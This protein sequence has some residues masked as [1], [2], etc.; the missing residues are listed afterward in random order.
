MQKNWIDVI[1][2]GPGAAELLT[3]QA[4]AAINSAEAVF[5]APRHADLA[6]PEKRRPLIPFQAALEEMA[7]LPRCAVLVSGDAGLYSML[8]LLSRRFGQDRLRVYPGVSSVQALCAR[9]AIAWQ[10]A[11][12][13]SAHG[14]DCPPEALCHY[15]RT[16]PAVLVLLDAEHDP[17]W[18][19]QALAAGNLAHLPLV[20]GERV[21]YPDERIAPYGMR[22]YDS[23]SAALI[24]NP[25]P[26]AGL[27]PMGLPD[28]AFIRGKTPM[29]KR[30]VRVQ[31]L[32]ALRLAPDA[33]VWDIGAGT[34]SVTV[35]CA[36]QCPL[37]Q[38]YAIERDPDALALIG[39]NA[40]KFH[41]Q[42]IAVVPGTAPAALENLPAPTHV[43]LGGAAGETAAI[44]K[45]LPSGARVCAT[46]V[47]MESAALLTHSL[48]G[49]Q[50]FSA[51][52][53]AV[54]RLE[55]VGS[56]RMFRAQ[57]PVFVFSATVGGIQ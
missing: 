34:G 42:N 37:G 36:R 15:A 55:P 39:R 26:E 16:N 8:G 3:L 11:K 19:H 22:D 18:V 41:L 54:S 38:V 28:E 27:P 31:A 4:Q 53:I 17:H 44:L 30:E 49:Y 10:D 47:T 45:L 43:F 51:V 21:S 48:A 24:S 50:D 32:S 12:I 40:E 13:L 56:Y 20:I 14:R 25:S 6:P 1:S 35:E 2:A 7:A 52:Q 46:A 23:L 29:T 9:L 33:V 57:N 5:C